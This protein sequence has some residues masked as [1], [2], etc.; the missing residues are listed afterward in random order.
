MFLTKLV[1]KNT[2]FFQINFQ[3][4]TKNV[5]NKENLF[6]TSKILFLKLYGFKN[7]L[8]FLLLR[9]TNCIFQKFKNK[10]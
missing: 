10:K 4:R 3:E 2:K 7:N 1:K 6:F 8:N 9:A 5:L